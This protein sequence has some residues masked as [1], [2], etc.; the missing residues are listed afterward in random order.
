MRL[1]T[2]VYSRIQWILIDGE[3]NVSLQFVR[4]SGS[5]LFCPGEMSA[6]PDK[7]LPVIGDYAAQR[8]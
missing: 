6:P 7:V 1:V 2:G 4:R 8:V 3:R 5:V